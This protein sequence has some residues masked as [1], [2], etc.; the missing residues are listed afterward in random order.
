MKVDYQNTFIYKLCCRDPTITDIYVGHSTNFK[1]R[2]Q[3]HK[4]NCNNINGKAYNQYN[5]RF[6]R[7]NSGYDNFIMIKLYDYPCNSKREAEAEETKTMIE[8]GATLNSIKSFTTEEYKKEYNKEW[9]KKKYENNKTEIIE[10]VRKYRQNNKKIVNEK[11]KEYYEKNKKEISEK[12]KVKVKCEFCG[13][14]ITK[15]YLT[16]HQK[17]QKCLKFREFIDVE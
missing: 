13:C 2:N 14:E 10:S 17:T 11:R 1:Q 3:G 5:Y 16:T 4:D 6:I 8:L 7:E 12:Q 9:N 15:P